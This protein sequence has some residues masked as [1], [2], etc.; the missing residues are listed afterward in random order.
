MRLR[1]IQIDAFADRV[2]RGNPAAVMPLPSWL[3]DPVLQDIAVENNLSETAFYVADLPPDVTATPDDAPAYHL[4]WFTPAVEVDLCGHATLATAG[5][6]FEDVHPEAARI[7]FWTRSGWLAVRRTGRDGELEL[8][9]PAG[10]LRPVPDSDDVSAVAVAALGIEP[11]LRLRDTDL[12][13][14]LRDA[15]AV[16]AV[17]P[18]FTA[19]GRLPVR[20]VLVTAPGDTDGVDF[21]SRFFGADAGAFEDPVTGSAHSQIAPYWAERLGRPR[22]TA[23]QLSAR[24]G[25]VGCEVDGDRVRLRGTWRRYLDGT[26][27]IPEPSR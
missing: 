6:L 17:L 23:R 2:F 26:A 25:T 1:L 12:V 16:R 19:L 8:D 5:H 7:H 15:E 14:V 3:P 21:V 27:T 10:N 22:L 11:E 9:F 20:G 18:D 24:G 4:R 13:Y